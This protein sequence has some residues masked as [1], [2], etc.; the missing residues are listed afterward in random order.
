MKKIT[1]I[2]A[3]MITSVMF[4]QDLKLG[5][6]TGESGG[7]AGGPF[8]NMPAPVVEAG[9][10]TNTSQVLKIVGSGGVEVWQGIN[11]NL[12]SKVELTTTKT[13]TMDVLSSTPITFLVK[14]NGGLSGAPEAAAEVTHNGNGQWQTIS[15]TFNTALDNK[16]PTANG[17]YGSFVI[18]AYWKAGETV[19]FPN[20]T[21]PARTFYV[22]NIKG[23]TSNCTNGIQDGSETGI[24]CGGSCTPCPPPPPMPPTVNS[25]MPPNRLPASVVSIYGDTYASISPINYDAGWCGGGSVEATTAGGVGNNVFAYKGNGCQGITFPSAAKNLTGFTNIHV[26]LFIATGTNLVG[27]VFNLKI[28]P[29]T[30]G[31]AAEVVIPIDIN[32]LVPVPTP[33]TWYS[34]DTAFTADDLVK[35]AANPTMH[36]FGITSNLNNAVWY[37]NLYIHQN[38]TLGTNKFQPSSVKMY[39]NPVKNTLTIEANSEIQRV[40]VYNTLGQEVLKASPKSNTATLQTNE[41]Q[42][43]V[44][45]V[46]TEIDGNLSTSKVVK[47]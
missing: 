4:S 16:A 31:G 35:L 5:F 37:D 28:V 32:G 2:V 13:M 6:E 14:V 36:E 40:S 1:L 41:L 43:G 15:F 18:H 20:V 38:T 39:P 26:D 24:D 21:T 34:F 23:P 10:G 19:F 44:Y 9:T 7:V 42:K 25:P 47:E 12:T 46:T 3:L 29:T 33:G 45:M 8:G 22:D 27:K 30:G 11:L 17:V